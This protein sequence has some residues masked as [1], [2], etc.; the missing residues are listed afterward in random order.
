VGR[1]S[2]SVSVQSRTIFRSRILLPAFVLFALQGKSVLAQDVPAKHSSTVLTLYAR[3]V[4]EDVVVMDKN[5]RAV[6]G[7]TKEDFRILENG[8]PQTITFFEP[9]FGTPETSNQSSSIPAPNTFTNIPL[10]NSQIVTNVLLLDAVNSWPED[11][12]YAHVQMVKYLASLP[13]GLRIGIFTL[14]P[15]KLNLIWPL[16]E[17]S[18]IL[19]E[20]VAKS[21]SSHSADSSTTA[22]QR[23]ALLTALNETAQRVRD[24]RLVDS[25]SALQKFLQHGPGI[26]QQHNH[27][28]LEALQA[29]ARYLAGI[30]GRKN[31]FW[32][33]GNFPHCEP[34]NACSETIDAL[35]DAGVSLYPI[36]AHGVDVDMGLGPDPDF[37]QAARRFI[38]SE[39]W[40]EDTG[41]KAYHANDIGHEIA[42]AVD[43]GSRY[44][45]LAYVPGDRKE[46]GRERTVDVKVS[47]NYT[48]FFRKRYFEQRQKDSNEA[49]GTP[50][51]NPL[52]PLMGHGLPN[53]GG[54]PYHLKVVPSA[55]QPR[56]GSPRAGK[57]AG[58]SGQITRY[59]VEFQLEPGSLLL[60][61][62]FDGVRRKSVQAALMIYGGN[63]KPLNWDIREIHLLIKPD[64]WAAQQNTGL[65]FHTEI[66]APAGDV[67]LRTGLYDSA[68]SKVGTLEIPLS[69]VTPAQK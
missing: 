68:S 23:Q 46:D 15:D 66:D 61:P 11:Q 5:G 50:G 64:Q 49:R 29:L 36:D 12:M 18:S 38:D 30:P 44:Y 7:L 22:I 41:G 51:K 63:F 9:N 14:T 39:Y 6:P 25:A 3:T 19:R 27:W 8:R 59:D 67:Y 48:L 33:V 65:T 54:I 40:A 56:P 57:N 53:S 60:L 2:A 69:A 45:T 62:D 13:S 32:I 55:T 24:S 42:D 34:V 26:I 21:V 10:A 4:V 28:S 52:L 16:N 58:L 47:G 43:H 37:H 31:L 35:G 1:L 17:D 20:T